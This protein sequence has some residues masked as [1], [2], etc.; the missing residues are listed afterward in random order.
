MKFCVMIT[1]YNRRQCLYELTKELKRQEPDC[2][3][4]VIDDASDEDPNNEY[5]DKIL[6]NKENLAKYGYWKT[7]NKL[8]SIARKISA[9]YYIQMVDDTIPL[10]RFFDK[11]ELM[12]DSID[13]DNKVALHLANNGREKNWTG[14]NRTSYNKDIYLT[15]T[16]ETTLIGTSRFLQYTVPEISKD[17]WKNNPLLGSGVF[18]SIS[19]YWYGLGNNIYGVKRSLITNNNKCSESL[20][21]PE[22]RQKHGW[23][24]L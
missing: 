22:A 8:W 3:I 2:Y 17:R 7:I 14:Y 19:N 23:K 1:T 10:Q 20:M 15:Q 18:A 5:I 6:Y 11:V 24:I 21:N 13:D 9:E 12:W 16:T 4:I